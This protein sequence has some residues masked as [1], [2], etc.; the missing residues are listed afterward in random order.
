MLHQSVLW[1][2]LWRYLGFLVSY[3][4]ID[5]HDHYLSF[6]KPTFSIIILYI[7]SVFFPLVSIDDTA[8]IWGY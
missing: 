3:K 4:F 2:I 5:C 7:S 6:I 8:N 1:R